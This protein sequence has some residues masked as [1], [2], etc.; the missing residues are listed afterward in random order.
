MKDPD[1]NTRLLRLKHGL[2]LALLT[3]LLLCTGAIAQVTTTTTITHFHLDPAGTP[4]MATDEA[5]NIVWKESYQPYGNKQNNPAAA[6]N[7]TIGY[8]GKPYDNQTGLSYMGARYY[9]PV[10]GRFMGMDPVG[11]QEAN[12]HSHNRYAYANNNPYKFVD[13]DGRSPVHIGLFALGFAIDAGGRS[14]LVC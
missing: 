12:I 7:N 9:H 10:L 14:A 8:A 6:D 13:P 4:L 1:M 5:G 3:A 11:Y 2:A